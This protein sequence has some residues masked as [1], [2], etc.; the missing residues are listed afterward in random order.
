VLESARLGQ[1]RERFLAGLPLVDG[2][3]LTET[4][5][6]LRRKKVDCRPIAAGNA[7]LVFGL[8]FE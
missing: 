2:D 8:P 7:V 5:V 3:P 6:L 4:K 1:I